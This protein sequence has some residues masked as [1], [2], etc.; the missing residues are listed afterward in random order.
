MRDNIKN[1]IRSHA[2]EEEKAEMRQNCIRIGRFGYEEYEALAEKAR[3]REEY[4]FYVY[5]AHWAF[6]SAEA[7]VFGA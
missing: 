3:S 5:Q 2:T 4:D 7:L 1:F 6:K